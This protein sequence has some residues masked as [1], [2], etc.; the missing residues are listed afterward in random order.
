MENNYYIAIFSVC[1]LHFGG[2]LVSI[3]TTV[4]FAKA[5]S[6]RNVASENS[7]SQTAAY[8]AILALRIGLQKLVDGG[9]KLP[10][11]A[12]V[13][14][15]KEQSDDVIESYQKLNTS[16]D[17]TLKQLTGLLSGQVRNQPSSSSSSSSLSWE[18]V[19][20]PQMQLRP[21][22]EATLDKW[23]AR[24]HFGTEQKQARMKVFNHK[25]WDQISVAL[26]DENRAI[27]KSRMPMQDS[28]RLD[29]PS[30]SS[31]N[32]HQESSTQAGDDEDEESSDGKSKKRRIEH[33]LEVYDDRSFYSLLLKSFIESTAS[34]NN[35]NIESLRSADLNALKKY[36][37]SKVKVD[38][39]ASKGRKIRFVAHG[40]LQNFMFPVAL[41]EALID[42]DMLFNSLF[43]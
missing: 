7:K 25:L 3:N 30:S 43:Q 33:D 32:T 15:S 1:R 37:R 13:S 26:S 41:P 5:P 9:N 6:N 11:K 21:H 23:N 40:K 20:A 16:L 10:G 38:R 39:K 27:E 17:A 14:I 8:E 34:S 24:L 36:R 31:C 42:V 29:K 28:L 22:W 35:S 4:M 19:V 12:M 18:D 2:P